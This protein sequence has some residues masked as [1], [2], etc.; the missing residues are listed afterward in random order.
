MTE[1]N[2]ARGQE[3]FVG[4]DV[5]GTHTDVQV[6]FGGRDA[7][8]KALTTYDDFSRGVLDAIAVAAQNLDVSLAELLSRTKLLVN[9]TTVV[10]NAITQLR[11]A[12][13]GVLVTAGFK[14]EFRFAGGPRLRVVDDHLQ[15]NIPDLF[16]RRHL[17]EIEERI[18]YSGAEL[19]PLNEAQVEAAVRKLVD[20]DGVSA[21]AICFLSSYAD[22]THEDRAA[23]IANRLYPD[24]F[25][26]SSSKVSSVRGEY[27]RWMT[28]VL[29]AFVYDHAEH[30]IDTLSTKLHDAG[31]AGSA[32]FFQGLG[33]G[34][35]GE[36]ALQ[37]PLALLG[38][39]PAA[40]AAG[41]NEL[42]SRLGYKRVL[43]GDMGGTSF[44]TGL[45]YDNEVHVEKSI[46][47]GRFRTVLPLVDVV[48]VGAGGGSIAWI[49]ERGVPQVGPQSASS[50]PGPAAY[51]KGGTE[52]TV[53]DAMIVMGFIDPKNYLGGRVTLDPEA[54]A[55]AIR[56][57][58]GDPLG[59]TL[60][61]AAA[62]VHDLVVTNMANAVREV[63]VNK[64]YDPR[65]FVFLAY[66]GTLPGFAVE[67]ARALGIT[68][69]VIPR[70]SSVFCARG[71][72]VS[73]FLLRS[74][75]TVQSGLDSDSELERVNGVARQLIDGAVSELRGEGFADDEVKIV[76]T[77]DFQYTGQVHAL[78]VSL[79]NRDLTAADVAELNNTFT[80]VYERTYGSGTAWPDSPQQMLNYTVTVSAPM[81][82]PPIEP[83]PLNPTSLA[84][85]SKGEREI[86]LPSVNARRSAPIYDEARFTPGSRIVGPAL[87]EAVDTT[88]YLPPGARAERDEHMNVV[89]TMEEV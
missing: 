52:P 62:A 78:S 69:V 3:A 2:A 37:F 47:I 59:F 34:I 43:L 19:V 50:T 79:P 58:F 54:S 26:T 15:T 83:Q 25:V 24:L 21:I 48:S 84:E 66:G 67:I 12:K 11:G 1:S 40:G 23:K 6:V 76:R 4:V 81:P 18:D 35:S 89:I 14:D 46:Q 27:P 16:D 33:G 8:G 70:N 49:S 5:G 82:H 31:L 61:E 45:I 13:V 85:M 42:S 55:K 60:D 10:T 7:R 41:A 87:V 77:A 63:S 17:I 36:R 30:F 22:S 20:E 88:I 65:D 86:Y 73:D 38:A 64:G 28:A 74:D 29:N 80:S 32:A 51:G 56:T 71:L 9:A 57:R 39:G 53:T 72:L 75:Q 44:D 68:T